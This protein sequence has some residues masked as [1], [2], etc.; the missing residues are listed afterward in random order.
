MVSIV[1]TVMRDV[2][3]LRRCLDAIAAAAAGIEHE[4]VLVLSGADDEVLAFGREGD[5]G[6]RVVGSQVNLGF[7]GALNLGRRHAFGRYLAIV[8]DDAR[9][10]EGWPSG[11]LKALEA[12]PGPGLAGARVVSPERAV[13]FA[14][15]CSTP[16]WSRCSSLARSPG[17]SPSTTARPLPSSCALKH[18]TPPA[19]PTRSSFQRVASTSIWR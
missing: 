10:G 2:A 5:H 16:P 9:V 4:V 13:D 12:H 15:L 7:A 1:V 11:L 19:A 17:P 18:G 14:G 3:R 6:A 8:Q